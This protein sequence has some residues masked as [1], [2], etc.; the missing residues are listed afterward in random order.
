MLHWHWDN[1]M[2]ASAL[3]RLSWRV[4]VKLIIINP[5]NIQQRVIHVHIAIRLNGYNH[6]SKLC[7][8]LHSRSECFPPLWV[9]PWGNQCRMSYFPAIT[10]SWNIPHYY[11]YLK[12]VHKWVITSIKKSRD[13]ITH[14]CPNFNCGSTKPSLVD[15]TNGGLV[16]PETT[17]I[18]FSCMS[19]LE[20]RTCTRKIWM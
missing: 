8:Y 6:R 2:V 5:Q 16:E 4:L 15:S 7:R 20:V 12:N 1:R 11:T 14:S 19:W 9:S 13:I 17:S 18:V 10:Y 3:L